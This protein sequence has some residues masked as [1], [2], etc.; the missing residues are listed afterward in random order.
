MKIF[1]RITAEREICKKISQELLDVFLMCY[2]G[3]D[4]GCLSAHCHFVGETKKEYKTIASFR[5]KFNKIC[6]EEI[7]KANQYSI[8]EL[9][10]EE[11][12]EL[13]LCK[14]SKK[15]PKVLPEILI[16]NSKTNVEEKHQEFHRRREAFKQGKHDKVVWREFETYIQEN[17]P[18]LFRACSSQ[19]IFNKV[20]EKLY[21]F[22]IEKDKMFLSETVMRNIITTIVARNIKSNRQEFK[23]KEQ[24]YRRWIPADYSY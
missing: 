14:G 4:D 12:W 24:I 21:D 8:K 3:V 19:E 17:D 11:E 2:E 23:I 5:Q 18:E 7:G 20:A 16:N 15:D 13:Y 9:N 22:F 10:P 6:K 1:G